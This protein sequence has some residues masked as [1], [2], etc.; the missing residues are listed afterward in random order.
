MSILLFFDNIKVNKG[1]SYHYMIQGVKLEAIGG[2]TIY[3]T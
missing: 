3:I 2:I 1:N